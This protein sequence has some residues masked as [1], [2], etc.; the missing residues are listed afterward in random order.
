MDCES[1][2]IPPLDQYREYLKLFARVHLPPQLRGRVDPSDVVQD[3]YLKAIP[4][5]PQWKGSSEPELRSWLRAILVNVLKDTWRAQSGPMRNV[6]LEQ[7]LEA[8]LERS[9]ARFEQWLCDP[10]L[11]PDGRAQKEDQIDEIAQ[12][13][14]DVPEDQRTAVE[15]FYFHDV[16][17]KEIAQQLGR[18]HN[19][20]GALIRRGAEAIRKRLSDS[21]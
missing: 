9:S 19:A 5:L 3:V 1:S 7:S 15:L 17:V 18:S 14:N 20:A 13:I 4:A 10:S 21:S 8:A 11:G 2:G 16:P 12:A 6:K